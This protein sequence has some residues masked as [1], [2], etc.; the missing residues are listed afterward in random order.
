MENKQNWM[1]QRA[2][3]SEAFRGLLVEPDKIQDRYQVAQVPPQEK[4]DNDSEEPSQEDIEQ[5]VEWVKN[6][7]QI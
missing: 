4:I 1:V 5:L 7:R 6:R 3:R 2:M